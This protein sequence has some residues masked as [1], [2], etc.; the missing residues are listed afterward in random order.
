MYSNTVIDELKKKYSLAEIQSIFEMVA[1]Q[2][3]KSETKSCHIREAKSLSRERNVA[4]ADALH[5]IL[6][7]DNKA[8]IVSRDNHFMSLTDVAPVRKPE[9]L[10]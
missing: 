4:L 5:A 6:A 2:L 7:R 9:E 10:I 3:I 8:I 1:N